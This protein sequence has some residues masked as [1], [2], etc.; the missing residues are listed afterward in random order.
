VARA[1]DEILNPKMK[2]RLVFVETA[3][4]TNGELLEFEFFLQPGGV[5]AEEHLHPKQEERME[6]IAGKMRGRLDGTERTAEAGE[7]VVV[8]PGT[9][10]AW[11]ND[12]EGEAHLRVQ[13][14]PALNTEQQMETFFGLARD[15][16]TNDRGVPNLLR[17]AVLLN[18]HKDEVYPAKLPI[19]VLKG[20]FVVLAPIGRLLGYRAHYPAY[21]SSGST[22]GAVPG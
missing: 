6:V 13:F 9:P 19:P 5:I 1:G 20:L 18:E 8:P 16:K 10:H 17:I 21:S 14:R 4:D 11:W 3:R 15:G 2:G 7:V 22:A 12:G